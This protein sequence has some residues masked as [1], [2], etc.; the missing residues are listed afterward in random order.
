L[1][2]SG[3]ESGTV[4]YIT[5]QPRLGISESVGEFT[6]DTISNG[7]AGGSAKFAT[8]VPIG[9]AAATRI[10]AYYTR[11]GGYIDAVQPN[12]SVDKDVNHGYRAG[13]RAAFLFQPNANFSITPRT[14]YQTVDMKGWNRSDVFN[15]LANPYTTSRPEVE[16]GARRQVT[17]SEEPT[18]DRFLLTDFNARYKIPN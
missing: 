10:T 7:S 18:T 11:Y 13:T 15:I 2:G 17:Q 9:S 5:N 1:F 4:R 6:A 3:S 14:V 8:N 16:L 12:L